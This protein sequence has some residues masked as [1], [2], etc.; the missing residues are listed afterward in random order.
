[1][2]YSAPERVSP[3]A[4]VLS[5]SSSDELSAPHAA[6]HTTSAGSVGSLSNRYNIHPER[7]GAADHFNGSVPGTAVGT[8]SIFR[9]FFEEETL[10]EEGRRDVLGILR[11]Y[12]A[13]EEML[14]PV[15]NGCYHIFDFLP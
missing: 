14:P 7:L 12:A 6:S 11:G 2:S 13:R 3:Y 9:R 1:M 10:G 15:S 5:R 4:N 8:R